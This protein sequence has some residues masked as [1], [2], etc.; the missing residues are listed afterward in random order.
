MCAPQHGPRPLPLF[1]SNLVEQTGAKDAVFQTALE[2]LR[3]YQQADRP[4]FDRRGETVDR[5]HG[6]SLRLPF[7]IDHRSSG[8]IVVFV[9]SPVNSAQIFDISGA[10]SM[11]AWFARKGYRPYIVDWGAQ[12]ASTLPRGTDFYVTETLLPLLT[13]LEK[14][15]HLVGYCL[16]ALFAI[17]AQCLGSIASLSV[18][19]TPWD[20]SRYDTD[21]LQ[22]VAALWSNSEAQL[23]TL[24]M[25]PIEILQSAFWHLSKEAMVRKYVDFAHLDPKSSAFRK[26]VA[27]EDWTNSGAPLPLA[28]GRDVF[29]KMYARNVTGKNEWTVGGQRIQR[30]DFARGTLEIAGELDTLVPMDTGPKLENRIVIPS[31]HIGMLV[32]SKGRQGWSAI[33]KHIRQNSSQ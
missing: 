4:D 17:A 22:S 24:G 19:A 12:G 9:P 7:Q 16:G 28:L 25:V 5:Q 2:G 13:R 26:F 33:E 15:V 31:G 10:D 30:T 6:A 29:E 27:V 20:F 3:R 32:G 14:P 21:H 8:E 18:I 23:R 11:A 1:L